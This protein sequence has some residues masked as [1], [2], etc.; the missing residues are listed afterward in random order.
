MHSDDLDLEDFDDIRSPARPEL[1]ISAALHL[2][3]HY[4]ASEQESR[5]NGSCVRLAAVIERHLKALADLPGLEPVL[6]ATCNQLSR[7]WAD[8][9]ERRIAPPPQPGLL[10]RLMR[11]AH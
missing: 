11:P 7:Q 9:V 2:M 10:M 1:L 5:G 6:R 4:A 8:V 3:S